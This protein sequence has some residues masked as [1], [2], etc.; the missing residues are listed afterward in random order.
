MN[1]NLIYVA[2]GSIVVITILYF[3]LGSNRV[4]SGNELTATVRMGK[5]KVEITTTGELEA[6]RSVQVFGPSDARRFRIGSFTIDKMVDEGTVVKQG[7]FICS[8]DKTE[9][10]GRLEDKRLELDQTRAQYEQ[11]QL[12]TS[13]N[14]RQERDNIL[15]MEY[16]VQEQELILEQSQY[17][18]PA[19]I[20]QNQY[21]MEKAKR[22]LS[23]ARER[24]RI[25]TLQE[26]ARMVEIGA[27]LREV[28]TEV[29]Q[30]IEVLDKF[31]VK[32]PQDGMVIYVTN[33]GT[34]VREGSQISSWNP[35]VATLPDLTTMQS[36]TYV[37]EVDIRRVKIGQEVEI[38]LDAFPDKR[39][40]GKVTK[41]ANVGQ[42]RPNSDAKV[43]EV[44]IRIHESDDLLRPSMTTS[45]AIIADQLDN[46][47]YVPLE[48]INVENDSI[49][50]V[51]LKS[52]V[53]QEVMMG[54]TNAND[55][56]IEKGLNQGDKVYLS[57]PNWGENLAVKLLDE[58]NGKRSL[59]RDEPRVTADRAQ[60]FVP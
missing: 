9:L 32:A 31:V 19:I 36:I 1:K 39:F 15:N 5:F 23:Q 53:K 17:E 27:K 25:K 3:S 8:I 47:L 55:V 51:Y 22:E 33:R 10:F 29:D 48:A 41:V 13:L 24:Y 6:L 59:D 40:S 7:D 44:I 37:N 58:L 11:I 42:Q 28:Q 46:V 38:G 52:G 54:L 16:I 57:T 21:N 43:F 30:M 45:N 35:V 56:V 14:L 60:G 34:K 2:I 49:N 18:P 26:R 4:G 20:K 12:D 50:Y